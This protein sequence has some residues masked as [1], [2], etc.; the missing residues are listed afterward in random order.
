MLDAEKM[1]LALQASEA[2]LPRYAEPLREENAAVLRAL[3]VNAETQAFFSQFSFEMEMAAGQFTFLQTNCLKKNR[4]WE[5][6]FRRALQVNLLLVGSGLS[7]DIV[8]LDLLDYQIGILFHDY[9]WEKPEDNPRQYLIKMNCSLGQFY[10]N[11]AFIE[12]YPID[13]YEA[14]AYMG[15]EFTGYAD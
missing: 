1:L 4:D 10:W 13:A 15:S 3:G 5:D 9:F 12:G 2:N 6:D 8:T 11:S 14:A 7:G